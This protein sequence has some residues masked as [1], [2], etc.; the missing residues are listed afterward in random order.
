MAIGQSGLQHRYPFELEYGSHA[1]LAMSFPM[2]AHGT[3]V[4]LRCDVV[5]RE[6]DLR[7][8]SPS[9]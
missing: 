9:P 1:M 5:Q 8:L 3:A 7:F 6:I 2:P 4:H